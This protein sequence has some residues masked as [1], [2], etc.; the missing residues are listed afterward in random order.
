[1]FPAAWAGSETGDAAAAVCGP[2]KQADGGWEPE[3]Y[4][5]HATGGFVGCAAAQWTRNHD[6]AGNM[7]IEITLDA[8][9]G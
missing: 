5:D 9:L 2:F 1:M 6:P 8:G 7:E 3:M 4:Q